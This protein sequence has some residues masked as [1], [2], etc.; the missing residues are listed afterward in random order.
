MS[1]PPQGDP[2]VG[3]GECG[4][5]PQEV[6]QHT[7]DSARGHHERERESEGEAGRGGGVEPRA[8]EK[9]DR[10]TAQRPRAKCPC[11][12]GRGIGSR[13]MPSGHVTGQAGD[14]TDGD[15]DRD[16]QSV[17]RISSGCSRLRFTT[18]SKQTETRPRRSLGSRAGAS[19]HV[20]K[21]AWGEGGSG[22]PEGPG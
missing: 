13:P 8:Q 7:D 4:M 2:E 6:D 12:R 11:G 10:T 14:P 16:E 20:A 21:S 18:R 9:G 22:D 19:P 5:R 17:L 1:G 15:D 3:G